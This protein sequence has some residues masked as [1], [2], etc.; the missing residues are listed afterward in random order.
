MSGELAAEVIDRELGAA[1]SAL[2]VD[3]DPVPIAAASIGQVHRAIVVDPDTGLERAVAVKVQYPGV[4]EAITA[5]LANA[6]MLG[7][8][9]KQGF[10]SLD[11]TDMVEEIRDG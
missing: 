1:P 3:W 2:F 11:P 9:L 6:D 5:D 7:S 4:R 8:L 10:G